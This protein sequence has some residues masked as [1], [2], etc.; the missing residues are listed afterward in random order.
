MW[1]LTNRVVNFAN[2]INLTLL[3]LSKNLKI[4]L[5]DV[6]LM[7]DLISVDLCPHEI[8]FRYTMYM[9]YLSTK[10]LNRHNNKLFWAQIH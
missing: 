8:W 9:I 3:R 5:G 4:S 2:F 10:H 6:M 1:D 7:F